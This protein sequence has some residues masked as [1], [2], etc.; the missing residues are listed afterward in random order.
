MIPCRS[1]WGIAAALPLAAWVAAALLLPGSSAAAAPAGT[2]AWESLERPPFRV[3][4]REGNRT[5]ARELAEHAP[6]VLSDLERDLGLSLPGQV[7]ILIL[8]PVRPSPAGIEEG[9]VPDWAVGF[10][11]GG[12]GQVVLRGDLVRSY[13]FEDLLSLLGHELTHVLLASLPAKSGP[14]PHWFNEGVAVTESR[15]W[16]FRDAFTLSTLLLSGPSPRL[17][18]L[19]D[20]FPAEEGAARAAYAESFSFIAY[21]ERERGPGAVRRILSGME[22]GSTF[23]EAFRRAAGEDLDRVEEKWRERVNFAYR[24]VPALSSTGVLWMGITLLVLVSRVAK[25]RRERAIRESWERQGIG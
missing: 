1:R 11:P 24:W 13:P 19:A 8:P 22:A 14:V 5:E 15:R 6:G 18:T 16:S 25:R 10:V 21:L 20:S 2:G 4:Y 17:A 7:T 23:P 12:S 3:L 9:K